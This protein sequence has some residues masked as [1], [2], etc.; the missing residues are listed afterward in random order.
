MKD[1]EELTTRGRAR[2]LR[3]LALN[4]LADYELSRARFRLVT[5]SFN[6]IFR[7]DTD[8]GEKYIVRVCLPEERLLVEIQSEMAWLAALRRD[9]DLQVP[10]PVPTRTGALVTTAVAPGVPEP[11]HVV[12]FSWLPGPDL[13][14]RLSET[15]L[16]KL[17]RLTARLHDHADGFHP[18]DGFW[19]K[20]Y[21]TTFPFNEEVV[22]FDERADGLMP[23]ARR[24]VFK[25]AV[26]RV[27]RV[28]AGLNRD[29]AGLR[30]LHADLHQENVKVY[31]GQLSV[32]DFDDCMWGYPVQ[33]IAISMYYFQGYEAYPAYRRAFQ[34]GYCSRRPWPVEDPEIL[35]ALI[36]GR[37][38]V[39]ANY[40]L[41]D[42]NPDFRAMA[43]G[44]LAR[45]EDRLRQWLEGA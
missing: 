43:P 35:E 17:G 1:F 28:I 19:L 8:E 27:D 5:N 39:L 34:E 40:I 16:Y 12:V 18:P 23:P 20:T 44:F 33:D 37:G 15:N 22:L 30:V 38:L 45:T 6:G 29:P 36:G 4:A 21:D 41:M 11:R 25:E 7:L 14:E 13:A 3:R 32:L 42:P 31:R 10:K 26:E 9:T 24:A 2:R